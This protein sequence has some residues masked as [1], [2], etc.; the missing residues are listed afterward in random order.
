LATRLRKKRDVQLRSLIRS[1]SAERG[2]IEIIDMGGTSLYW[3]RVGFD[4][5]RE[6]NAHVTLVNRACN[7]LGSTEFERIDSVVGDAC[8]LSKLS[9]LSFDLAHSNSVI[10]HVVTWSNMKA[11]AAETRRLA[12]NYYVQTPYFWFPID[13]HYYR[14]PL[15]HW[16]PRPVRARLLHKLPIAHAG[17]IRDPEMVYQVVDDARLM[18]L[19]QFRLLFPDSHVSFE[20]FL[21]LRKSMVAVRRA[22]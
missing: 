21:G 14:I 16:L 4:F 18:D 17:T 6:V 22:S 12:D 8:R 3:D 20:R 7:E 2:K 10:E 11:F 1:I 5:L 13:P 9:D 15:F 19:H